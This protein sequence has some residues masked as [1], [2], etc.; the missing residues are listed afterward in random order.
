MAVCIADHPSITDA[1]KAYE[2]ARLK[3]V[4]TIAD[5]SYRIGQMR[6]MG[7]PFTSAMR[8]ILMRVIPESAALKLL[9]GNIRH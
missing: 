8:N 2:N 4:R 1:F 5:R 9:A 3:R 6:Q 7:N